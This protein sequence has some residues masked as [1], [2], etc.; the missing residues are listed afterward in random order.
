MTLREVAS[1]P[2]RVFTK[3][4]LKYSRYRT[5]VYLEGKSDRAFWWRLQADMC[6][7][8]AVKGKPNV[9]A[10]MKMVKEKRPHW[11]NVV[12]IIDPDFDLLDDRDPELPNLLADDKP[13]LE[14][15]LLESGALDEFVIQCAASLEP[16]ELCD[17]ANA[18]KHQALCLATQFGY[19]RYIHHTN[20]EYGLRN[21]KKVADSIGEY[22]ADDVLIVDKIAGQLVEDAKISK[23]LLLNQVENLR[24]QYS[25]PCINLCRGKDVFNIMAVILP[26]CFYR[27]FD[28][29]IALERLAHDCEMYS[30]EKDETFNLIFAKLRMNYP[31]DE[32]KS[33]V[34]H[35]RI[36]NWERNNNPFRIIRNPA[37]ERTPT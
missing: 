20:P 25:P 2:Q 35:H 21:L 15:T 16:P 31:I 36:R 1:R 37:L 30:Q 12:A 19:F 4:K 18:W 24:K 26:H 32:F 34:L 13:D 33:T 6:R 10:T 7:V 9:L 27:I 3:L 22:V 11:L 29:E 17:F 5:F 23:D 14:L 28:D 8:E